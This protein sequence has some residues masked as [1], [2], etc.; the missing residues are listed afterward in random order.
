MTS[1]RLRVSST[2]SEGRSAVKCNCWRLGARDRNEI[3]KIG[4]R[5][6]ASSTIP[7]Q[8]RLTSNELSPKNREC[9][10]G[11]RIID[12][13]PSIAVSV[14]LRKPP[15]GAEQR[16][17]SGDY[18]G[19]RSILQ[20]P[21]RRLAEDVLAVSKAHVVAVCFDDSRTSSDAM[22]DQFAPAFNRA[23]SRPASTIRCRP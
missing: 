16:R 3:S 19:L 5:H 2:N 12:R 21:R 13:R 6:I 15:Q 9:S 22:T 8:P 14:G 20:S 10:V 23:P 18:G 1:Q 11:A 7:L 4:R 17:W